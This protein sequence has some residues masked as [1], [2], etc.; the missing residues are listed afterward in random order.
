MFVPSSRL[1]YSVAAVLVPFATVVG[2]VPSQ[3]AFCFLIISLLVAAVIFDMARGF[4]SL[5]GVTVLCPPTVRLVK[6]RKGTI[7]LI[8][9]QPQPADR[10]IVV[11]LAMPAEFNSGD[12][13]RRVRIPGENQPSQLNWECVGTKRGRFPLL[14][15][16]LEAFSPWGFWA[17]RT[18]AELKSELRVYP[19]LRTDRRQVSALFL[20]RGAL[21]TRVH[22]QAGKGR[23]FEKLREYLPSDTFEDIH[24]KATAKRGRPVTKVFQIERTQEI[25]VIVDGSRLS[26]RQVEAASNDG[27]NKKANILERYVNAALVLCWAAERQGDRF[28]L[29]TFADKVYDFI[30]AR[31]GPAHFAVCRESIHTLQPKLVAPDFEELFAFVRL[32]LRQRS[33]IVL[34]T[35]L[36]DPLLGES[37]VRHLH[38]LSRQHLVLVC[39]MQPPG[40]GPLFSGPEVQST[41]DIYERLAGH[42]RWKRLMEVGVSVRRE[43]ALFSLMD[44]ERLSAQVVSQYLE[45]RQRQLL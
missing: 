33:L 27:P 14:A 18:R 15:C 42:L 38:V 26:A 6:D 1:L 29:I 16:Y 8:V 45:A 4:D 41:D 25:Y 24:W 43:G 2:L 11:G 34:L 40:I 39:L 13:L 31:N 44:N 3:A 36:D 19:D 37:F 22:R 7:P 32:R 30:R 17:V 9:R 35:A 20:Q 28:G 12:E 21:G 10:E 23:E 5:E